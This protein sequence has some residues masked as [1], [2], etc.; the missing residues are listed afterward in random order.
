MEQGE[1]ERFRR[2]LEMMLRDATIPA[3]KREEIAVQ[4]APDAVDH[5]QLVAERDLAIHQIE[6][7]FN[8]IQSIKR[9][10]E[11]IAKG[12]YGTCL[13]CDGEIGLKRLQAVPSTAYCVRCQELADKER[14]GAE[15][16][17]LHALLHMRDVA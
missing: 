4:S 16:E 10:L 8:R 2:L 3:I 9:A 5:S 7:N 17:G 1:V 12:S 15:G 13:M 6:T 11:R 14:K